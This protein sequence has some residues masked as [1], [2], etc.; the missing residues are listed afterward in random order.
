MKD[1]DRIARHLDMGSLDKDSVPEWENTY[2]GRDTGLKTSDLAGLVK[3]LTIFLFVV[4]AGLWTGVSV[5]GAAPDTV[6]A[7]VAASQSISDFLVV[8]FID[9]GQGNS[10]LIRVP[11][12]GGKTILIDGGKSG[13][14]YSPFDAGRQVV[15]PFLKSQGVQRLDQIVLTHTHDDHVGGLVAVLQDTDIEVAEVLD[16]MLPATSGIYRKYLESIRKRGIKFTKGKA[17]MLLDWGPGVRA[18]VLSPVREYSAS[19]TN[20]SSIVIRLTCGKISF[21]L[22]GDAEKEPEEDMLIYGEGLKSDI[23]QVPHHGGETS[24]SSDFLAAVQPSAAIFM[25]GANNKFGHPKASIL[26]KYE[27]VGAQIY[28]TDL[29]GT[30]TV[31][32]NGEGYEILT[33]K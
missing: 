19:T 13:N 25:V 2:S 1:T 29:S 32:T 3:F 24:S 27:K 15:V 18:Q 33:E 14:M 23:I 7:P 6:A 20:N 10:I 5:R 22:T 21:M 28:R 8:D 12:S 31:V 30:L 16:P 26:K 4:S 9:V 11:G 17:G